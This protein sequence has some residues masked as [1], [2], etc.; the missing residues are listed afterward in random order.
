VARPE[1]M[2]PA[3]GGPRSAEL[4]RPLV[5]VGGLLL[6]AAAAWVA[7][8]V[9]MA[10]MDAGPGSDPG[11]LGFYASTWVVMMAAMMFPSLAPT[12]LALGDLERRQARRGSGAGVADRGLFL[13][14]YLLTWAAAGL[15]AYLALKAGRLLDGGLFAWGR[16]GRWSAAAVLLLAAL[17]ELTPHKRTCLARCRSPRGFR[18][19]AW[20]DGRSGALQMGIEHGAWCLGCCWALM[21]ALFALGAMS[22]T[23]MLVISVLI[24]AEKL[25]PWRRLATVGVASLLAAVAI[26]LAGAPERVPGLT[27]PGSPAA[28]RAMGMSSQ[29]HMPMQRTPMPRSNPMTPNG[30]MAP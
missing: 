27:I 17:Y 13:A 23:W 14:G 29:R 10:G 11:T 22:L 6:L 12:V 15:L 18:Q 3:V 19:G 8:A 30:T 2:L 4:T 16:A 24:A 21:A 1:G 25:L 5:V 9:R 20:R 7:T 28:Q 26:G